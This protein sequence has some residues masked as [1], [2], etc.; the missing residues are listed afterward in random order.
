MKTKANFKNDTYIKLQNKADFPESLNS[1]RK[2]K[3][4]T[5]LI[6]YYIMH[7]NTNIIEMKSIHCEINSV[8]KEDFPDTFEFNIDIRIMRTDIK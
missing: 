3:T 1:H 7:L 4:D 2:Q 5:K 8:I 6:E